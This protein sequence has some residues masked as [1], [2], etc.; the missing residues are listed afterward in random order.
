MIK[1][2]PV[3]STLGEAMEEEKSFD[4]SEAMFDYWFRNCTIIMQP[5]HNTIFILFG[6]L[7][8]ILEMYI[9]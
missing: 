3:R 4:T 7:Q 8:S 1:Y 6:I 9:F 2:R 5:C